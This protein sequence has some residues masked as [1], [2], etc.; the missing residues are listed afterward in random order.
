MDF[1]TLL[2]AIAFRRGKAPNFRWL[3][4]DNSILINLLLTGIIKNFKNIEEL[5]YDGP[6]NLQWTEAAQEQPVFLAK[7]QWFTR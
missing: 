2:V 3:P 4:F 1:G 6:A 7:S 5:Q